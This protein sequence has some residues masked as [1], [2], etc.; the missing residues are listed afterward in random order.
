VAGNI[1]MAESCSGHA[2]VAI[3]REAVLLMKVHI[4]VVLLASMAICGPRLERYKKSGTV[5]PRASF[6][7]SN[8]QNDTL[9]SYVNW[10]LMLGLK[11]AINAACEDMPVQV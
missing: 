5:T 10:H 4:L 9:V 11:R 1:T 2:V 3:M 6:G 8:N 7:L